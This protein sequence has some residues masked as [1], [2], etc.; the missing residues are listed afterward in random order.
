MLTGEVWTDVCELAEQSLA[1]A[2]ERFGTFISMTS[3]ALLEARLAGRRA[4]QV[5]DARFGA[6]RFD[7][8]GICESVPAH[9]NDHQHGDRHDPAIEMMRVGWCEVRD[10]E[11]TLGEIR[12]LSKTP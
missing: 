3:T 9:A 11:S 8:L 5:F 1:A 6:D 10:L 4:I 2:F 12:Q 7:A